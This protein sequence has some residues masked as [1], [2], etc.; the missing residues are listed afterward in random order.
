MTAKREWE[1]EPKVKTYYDST[2]AP[3]TVPMATDI[4]DPIALAPNARTNGDF[5]IQLHTHLKIAFER[6]LR[7]RIGTRGG[8][9]ALEAINHRVE[10][11]LLVRGLV[12]RGD[13]GAIDGF[14]Q[15]WVVGVVF[16]HGAEVVGTLKQMGTLT[17]GVFGAYGL[18]IDALC[19]ETL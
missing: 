11:A 15:D 1:P 5:W 8:R 3:T 19:R 16:L 13:G 18:T 7:D 6:G 9:V 10:I 2:F 17:A 12:G 14:M 4:A